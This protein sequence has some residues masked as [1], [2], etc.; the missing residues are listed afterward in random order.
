M[1]RQQNNHTN[2]RLIFVPPAFW[3]QAFPTPLSN[4]VCGV[5]TG[6]GKCHLF[7]AVASD[8]LVLSFSPYFSI[9]NALIFYP[10]S[11]ASKGRNTAMK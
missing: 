3:G 10:M 8:V 1:N 2:D 4:Q 7:S 9:L 5:I 11:G 6:R